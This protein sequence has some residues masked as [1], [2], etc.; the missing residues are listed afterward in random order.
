M[1]FDSSS[2]WPKRGAPSQS[3]ADLTWTGLSL[4]ARKRYTFRVK[5]VVDACTPNELD[6]EANVSGGS[7]DVDAATVT[8]MVK[9]AK[10]AEPCP[11]GAC[12]AAGLTVNGKA[13]YSCGN[14]NI[15]GGAII[16]Q[17]S[18]SP[19]DCVE[20]CESFWGNTGFFAAY[21]AST[22]ACACSLAVEFAAFGV[23]PDALFVGYTIGENPDTLNSADECPIPPPRPDP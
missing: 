8:T 14:Y 17:S 20:A 12:T 13:V 22:T 2:T 1:D 23:I 11:T 15:C 5:M 19:E 7:C 21:K 16:S 10:G 9:R 4:A 18:S 6:F 3:G